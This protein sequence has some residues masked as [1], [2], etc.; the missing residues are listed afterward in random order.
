MLRL[1]PTLNSRVKRIKLRTNYLT[2]SPDNRM[3]LRV[4]EEKGFPASPKQN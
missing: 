2:F 4:F 3:L 1:C